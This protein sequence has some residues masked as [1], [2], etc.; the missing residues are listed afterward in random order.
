MAQS[1]VVRKER[2]GIAPYG[3]IS[4][5]IGVKERKMETQR[6]D[7]PPAR[8]A[9]RT[10]AALL[11]LAGVFAFGSP[12]PVS[13]TT[14]AT[15]PIPARY[16]VAQNLA[17]PFRGQYSLM[18]A[19]RSRLISGAMAIDLNALGYLFGVCQFRTYD[20]Q[21]YQTTVLVGFYNFHLIPQGRMLATIY[22]PT[23]TVV[24][25]QMTVKHQANGELIGQL[26][27][28]HHG[29]AVLWHK[30]HSL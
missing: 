24:L 23:D 5:T 26:T 17:Q 12:G 2:P 6:W 14:G 3:L 1:P 9:W 13:A 7:R 10:V 30:N 18:P 28:G 29:Y 21:G 20:A 11:A 8:W 4:G 22:D 19:A 15:T 27:L 25:G 16:K